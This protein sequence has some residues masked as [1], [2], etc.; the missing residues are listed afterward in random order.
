MNIENLCVLYASKYHLSVILLEF[1]SKENTKQYKVN[2]V[3][4]NGIE[5]EIE[6]LTKKYAK[7]IL[8]KNKIN[9]GET[10]NFTQLEI[11]S[12]S[13]IIIDGNQKYRE[14]ANKR[15]EEIVKNN[16]TKNIKIINCY[17]FEDY[18]DKLEKI[19]IENDKV[20]YTSGIN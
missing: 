9:F 16:N 15:I 12:N 17:Y 2:T 3:L 10:K 14:E 5:N 1:L 13:I 18:R 7:K 8:A 6:L 20:L 11:E 4:E 19:F